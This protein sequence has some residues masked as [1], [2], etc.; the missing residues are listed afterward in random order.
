LVLVEYVQEGPEGLKGVGKDQVFGK[1]Q[2]LFLPGILEILHLV[3]DGEE[4][5]VHGAHVAGGQFGLAGGD[6]RHPLLGGHPQTSPGG[7]ADH[8]VTL[9]LDLGDDLFEGLYVG[10]R[11]AVLRVAGVHM[12]DCRP[13]LVSLKGIVRNLVRGNGQVRG[14]GRGVDGTRDGRS[15]YRFAH[16]WFLL[17]RGVLFAGEGTHPSLRIPS[18]LFL[19]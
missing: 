16:E 10:G 2:V 4:G 5:E 11:H 13:G 3:Q 15:E 14:H 12:T 18:V 8:H 9:A 17:Y 7:G 1:F 19:S 6:D